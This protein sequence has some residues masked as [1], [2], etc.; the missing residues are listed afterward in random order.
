MEYKC[1]ILL[2]CLVLIYL[3]QF[4]KTDAQILSDT[5]SINL[6]KKGI[7]CIYNQ[8]FNTA[9]EIYVKINQKY[10]ENP[11]VIF[12]RG[13]MTYWENY[14]LLPGST[15]S[16]SFENEMRTCIRLS[17]DKIKVRDK[18]EYLLANLCA[19][20][21]LITYYSNNELSSN[22]IHLASSTYR[23]IRRSFSYTSDY[24]D[25]FFFTGL[26]NY[27]REAYPKAHPVYKPLAILFPKGNREMGLKE[28][29]NSAANSLLL[30]AESYSILSYIFISYE[31]DYLKAF[32]YSR[33]L[34]ELYPS[35][36]E[37]LAEYIKNLILIRHYD[38]AYDLIKSSLNCESNPYYKAQISVFNGIINEK[39]FHQ[40]TRANEYYN[41]GIKELSVFG[42]FS[43]EY[44]AYA[45]FGL[46]RIC[47]LN[48]DKTNRKVYRKK[49]LDKADIK[50]INFDE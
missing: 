24:T 26:Y 30:K 34:H 7:D 40:Y 9:N 12:F 46:S 6:I 16:S 28:L 29:Q 48:G 25:F 50:K 13:M 44:A 38:E 31:N 45:Y 47:E 39:R 10:P 49:A 4:S 35:N 32:Y 2:K 37:F 27:Y 43:N 21:I 1:K 11:V 5:A 3:L 42:A 8:Q 20:G 17:E 33:T 36:L 41:S 14:P 22:A 23:Y 15:A 18:P 19:R